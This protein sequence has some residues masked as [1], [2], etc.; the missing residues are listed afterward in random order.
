[1][2]GLCYYGNDKSNTQ[3]L[4]RK[5]MEMILKDCIM[6]AENQT[7]TELVLSHCFVV[8]DDNGECFEFCHY[9]INEYFLQNIYF[10]TQVLKC[11]KPIF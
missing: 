1:M 10:L 5:Q 7:K 8:T 4:S 3:M 9:S 6:N 2:H 11:G